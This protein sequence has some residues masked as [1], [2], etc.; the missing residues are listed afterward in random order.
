M[1]EGELEE[2]LVFKLEYELNKYI[3][4]LSD[5]IIIFKFKYNIPRSKIILGINN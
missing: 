2:H 3:N 1:F 5:S 4:K